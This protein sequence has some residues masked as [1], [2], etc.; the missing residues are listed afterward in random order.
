MSVDGRQATSGIRLKSIQPRRA[1][2]SGETAFQ[3]KTDGTQVLVR[4]QVRQSSASSASK[5][6]ASSLSSIV[7]KSAPVPS[8]SRRGDVMMIPRVAPGIQ[9]SFSRQARMSENC[10]GG[11]ESPWRWTTA[12]A[13][14]VGCGKIR[15]VRVIGTDTP[16]QRPLH[17]IQWND[18]ESALAPVKT[19]STL[20]RPK[21]PN[22]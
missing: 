19:V 10:L 4:G 3:S 21:Y 16:P 8:V 6:A 22:L 15:F 20:H 2:M 14:A 7:M 12:N 18:A 9:R 1:N 13:P 5:I 17:S 11:Y